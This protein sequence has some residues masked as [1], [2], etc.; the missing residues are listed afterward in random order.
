MSARDHGEQITAELRPLLERIAQ[1]INRSVDDLLTECGVS[2]SGEWTKSDYIVLRSW[3]TREAS[4]F[5]AVERALR[6]ASTLCADIL[7]C[8]LC[9]DAEDE[10]AV[11]LFIT[12]SAASNTS[13]N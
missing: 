1:L 11:R 5:A 13:L 10:T 7:L 4:H 8:S 3:L 2:L 6:N 12:Q 9:A